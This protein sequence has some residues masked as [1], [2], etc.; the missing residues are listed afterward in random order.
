MSTY[1]EDFGTCFWQPDRLGFLIVQEFTA[2][3]ASIEEV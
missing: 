3:E 1:L 2:R